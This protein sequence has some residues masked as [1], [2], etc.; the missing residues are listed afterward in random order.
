MNHY[1]FAT[2]NI[3]L[4]DL[5]EKYG[6]PLYIYDEN[7]FRA[8]CREMKQLIDY[9]DFT[10]NYS[11]KANSNL[12]L[13]RIARA[14]GLYADAMSPGEISLLQAAGFTPEQIYFVPNNVD[15]AEFRYALE[16]NIVVS[17]DSLSQLERLGRIAPGSEIALRLNPGIGAGHH[18]KVV[19]AGKKTKFGIAENQIAE[20]K[21][22]AAEYN[23]K[24]IGINQHIGSL[25]MSPE[26]YVAAATHFLELAK[27]FPDLRLIDFGGGFGIPYHKAEGESRLDLESLGSQ[28]TR[29]VKEFAAQYPRRLT[30]KIE[31]GRYIAAESGTLL[32][33]VLALKE[34]GGTSYVGT[35]I[36][37]NVLMRPVLYDSHHD[38]EIY[39]DNKKLSSENHKAFT[40]VGNICE[41]GDIL[42]HQRL[43][44]LTQAGDIIAVR[45]AGAY[46]YAMASSYNSRP[47]PAEVLITSSGQDV[48]IRKRETIEDLFSLFPAIEPLNTNE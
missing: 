13:L 47:R 23:L 5:L 32:G 41:S 44:P 18:Q 27:S 45:D 1:P 29:L 43:L 33:R 25:F 19:T 39:R 14:E 37:F 42:A 46:G 21:R 6:S 15:D 48:L 4:A 12:S 7:V 40:V 36:G 35:D 17:V 24:I 28:V 22:L 3:S 16:R 10:A 11:I 34:N 2:A 31:P 38:L 30:F 9:P 26:P 8:R 20:A